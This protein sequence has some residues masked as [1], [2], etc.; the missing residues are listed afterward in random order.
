MTMLKE[1][2]QFKVGQRVLLPRDPYR[3]IRACVKEI[4]DGYDGID[5]IVVYVW[6]GDEFDPLPPETQVYTPDQLRPWEE[7]EQRV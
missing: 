6:W 5:R 3:Q 1:K 7:A 4:Y 2:A